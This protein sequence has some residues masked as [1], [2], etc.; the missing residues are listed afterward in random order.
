MQNQQ[1]YRKRL[2]VTVTT[3]YFL[4][5]NKEDR[6]E[7]R[8]MSRQEEKGEQT[9]RKWVFEVCILLLMALFSWSELRS[10]RKWCTFLV[11]F[12]NVI[13]LSCCL[14][15]PLLCL[16]VIPV[17]IPIYW[18]TLTLFRRKYICMYLC[19]VQSYKYEILFAFF[20]HAVFIRLSKITVWPCHQ[21][22]WMASSIPESWVL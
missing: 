17:L 14:L 12:N 18:Y 6:Q 5:E 4:S 20:C 11:S 16:K 21:L 10:L 3:I 22:H 9:R 13:K 8:V 19:G 2:S 1:V 7:E 15:L